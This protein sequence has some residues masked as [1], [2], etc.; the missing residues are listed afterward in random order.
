MDDTLEEYIQY[1]KCFCP[2]HPLGY[3]C[4]GYEYEIF[5]VP[6]PLD[7]GQKAVVEIPDR[8]SC[9]VSGNNEDGVV[10]TLRRDVV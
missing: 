4:S 1:L 6:V 7:P 8:V 3:Q 9:Q 5:Y 2:D 10:I